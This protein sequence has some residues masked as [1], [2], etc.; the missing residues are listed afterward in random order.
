M[1]NEIIWTQGGEEDLGAY[2]FAAWD[3]FTSSQR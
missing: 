2:F 1:L 3:I